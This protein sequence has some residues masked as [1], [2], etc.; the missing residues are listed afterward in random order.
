M[1][2]SSVKV[3]MSPK[4]NTNLTEIIILF[5]KGK[6]QRGKFIQPS[7]VYSQRRVDEIRK[8]TIRN[9]SYPNLAA[10]DT[11][12]R[13]VKGDSSEW[14]GTSCNAYCMVVQHALPSVVRD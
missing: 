7:T 4:T 6:R 2:V 1:Q 8:Q 12:L 11:G 9:P 13:S 5:I 14:V 10:G 3:E